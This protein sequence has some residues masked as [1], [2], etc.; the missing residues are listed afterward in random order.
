MSGID[1]KATAAASSTPAAAAADARTPMICIVFPLLSAE[2]PNWRTH[3]QRLRAMNVA[4][5]HPPKDGA[6]GAAQRCDTWI[7]KRDAQPVSGAAP[8]LQEGLLPTTHRNRCP[9]SAVRGGRG[10]GY[11][12]VDSRSEVAPRGEDLA[13]QVPVHPPP[14]T[15]GA[16]RLAGR[17]P[18]SIVVR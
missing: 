8:S 12:R 17:V 11:V 14:S 10:Q 6:E 15:S 7:S 4:A 13:I 3:R 5:A 16:T 1:L 18:L 2:T 9:R